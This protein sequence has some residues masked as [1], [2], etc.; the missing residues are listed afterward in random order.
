MQYRS[1]RPM[2][3]LLAAM[4]MAP[5][6]LAAGNEGTSAP[7]SAQPGPPVVRPQ[8][9]AFTEP[10]SGITFP[11]QLGGHR[12]INTVDYEGRVKG[13][14][15]SIGYR[16]E[17]NEHATVYL[18]DRGAPH[19]ERGVDDP[20]VRQAMRDAVAEIDYYSRRGMY[21]DIR[22]RQLPDAVWNP[23]SGPLP[24]L[25]VSGTA[26]IVVPPPGPDAQCRKAKTLIAVTGYGNRVLKLR[27][28]EF[29]DGGGIDMPS[30][31]VPFM[32]GLAGIL[33]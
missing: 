14:G 29:D 27:Y 12:I 28:T 4:A 1:I 3:A 33:R 20:T 10:G 22:L 30:G 7:P 6:T 18:F 9:D 23:P 13:G 5:I 11:Q 2:L 15:I 16:S 26:C 19:V 24:V 25:M 17:M 32:D 8:H 21:R 31:A